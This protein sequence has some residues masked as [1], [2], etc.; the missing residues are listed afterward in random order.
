MVT[1]FGMA[2]RFGSETGLTATAEILGTPSYTAPEVVAL[3]A[4]DAG[5]AVDVYALGAILY[6]CLTG[7]PRSKA[8][9]HFRPS[10]KSRKR[11]WCRPENSS[12][13]SR[14]TWKPSA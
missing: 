12:R 7:A 6:E 2:R 3:G 8:K 9:P 4:R 13:P 5:T 10:S 1:D 11:T 14:A